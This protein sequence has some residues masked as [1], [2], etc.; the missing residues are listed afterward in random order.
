MLQL[1]DTSMN[2]TGVSVGTQWQKVSKGQVHELKQ[3][4]QQPHQQ[5]L[6]Y[7]L[8]VPFVAK[9]GEGQVSEH[10]FRTNTF[11]VAS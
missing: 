10:H 7:E 4:P 1:E 5:P 8:L 9:T 6:K 3:P 11:W 2:G